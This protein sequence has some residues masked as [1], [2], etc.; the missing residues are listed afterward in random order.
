MYYICSFNVKYQFFPTNL[1]VAPIL[2][3]INLPFSYISLRTK[4][5]MQ[6]A[7]TFKIS[8]FTNKNKVVLSGIMKLQKAVF[9][10]F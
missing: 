3:I 1:I 4:Q 5:S 10:T 8:Y 6:L 7:V 9:Q 2:Q